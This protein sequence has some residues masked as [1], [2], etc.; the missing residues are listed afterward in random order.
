LQMTNLR[1]F[2]LML[3]EEKQSLVLNQMVVQDSDEAILICNA[4]PL[5]RLPRITNPK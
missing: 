2:G 5:L 3:E 1:I 4:R